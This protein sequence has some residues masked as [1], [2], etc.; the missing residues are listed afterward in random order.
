VA[1]VDVDAAEDVEVA[2]NADI[3]VKALRAAINARGS[4]LRAAISF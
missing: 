1:D 4:R 2:T 3:L